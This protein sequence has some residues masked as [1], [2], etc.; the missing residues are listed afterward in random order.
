MPGTAVTGLAVA[1]TSQ[2]TIDDAETVAYVVKAVKKYNLHSPSL[3]S[4][5]F[6]YVTVSVQGRDHPFVIPQFSFTNTATYN[7]MQHHEN[8]I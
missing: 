4:D 6:T 5:L 3:I 2:D 7:C 8:L 1:P